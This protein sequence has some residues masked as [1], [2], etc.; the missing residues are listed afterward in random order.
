[1]KIDIDKTS[2]I[3]EA[4]NKYDI[5]QMGRLCGDM[6]KQDLNVSIS[7]PSD[8]ESFGTLT[9]KKEDFV[10]YILKNL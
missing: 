6:H 3:L 4:E 5:F 7:L 8:E 2:V 1:M 9:I 10:S